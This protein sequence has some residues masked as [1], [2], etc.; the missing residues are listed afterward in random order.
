[1]IR[2]LE[3]TPGGSHS[4]ENPLASDDGLDPLCRDRRRQPS[5]SILA[6]GRLVGIYER[7]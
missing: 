1:M 5:N 7:P 2:L 6:F 3:E 4:G